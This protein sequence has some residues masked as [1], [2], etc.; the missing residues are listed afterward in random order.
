MQEFRDKV[1]DIIDKYEA[2][3]ASTGI[4]ITISKK[5]FETE[6]Q[7]RAGGHGAMAIF[8][9]IDRVRDRKKEKDNGYNYEKNKYHCIVLLVSPIDKNLVRRECCKEYAFVLRKVDRVHIG[10]EPIKVA[11]K[12][13][14][15]LAKIEKRILKIIK[16]SNKQSP[17]KICRDTI[18]DALR[19]S[20]LYKY[21]YKE[22]V[23]GKDRTSWEIFFAII[24]GI[25]TFLIIFMAWIIGKLL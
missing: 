24:A 6:V 4:K 17:Q 10:Q 25:L 5:Y 11:Y 12:E 7:E 3:L 20:F 9:A 8:N 22:R 2:S 21:E 1:Q 14:K 18:W 23:L 13:D 15:V 19:Y 16:K